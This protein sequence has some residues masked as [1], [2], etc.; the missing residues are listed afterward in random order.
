MFIPAT[1]VV[2]FNKVRQL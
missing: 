2:L 1:I